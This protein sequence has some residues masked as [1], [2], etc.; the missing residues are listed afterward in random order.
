MNEIAIYNKD[1]N[2]FDLFL[3]M[4]F[5]SMMISSKYNSSIKINV[6]KRKINKYTNWN[7]Y[8]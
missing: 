3:Y 8:I 1:N 4:I 2:Q 6:I 7:I 5:I